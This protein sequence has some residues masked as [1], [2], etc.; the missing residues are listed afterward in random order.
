[1]AE[2]RG[3]IEGYYGK[4]LTWDER[5]RLLKQMQR[6]GMTGYLYAPKEDALHRWQWRTPYNADWTSRFAAFAKAANAAH[7]DLVA[8]I[9][10]GLD[11][12]FASLGP[13]ASQSDDV[14]GGYLVLLL[15]KARHLLAAGA[16]G[17]AL[18]M[19]DIDANFATR[20]GAFTSE[21]VAHA[22]LANRL[23][24]AL[25]APLMLVPRIY[26]DSLIQPDDLHSIGYLADVT[27]VLAPSVRL[28]YCGDDIVA[29]RPGRD[30]AGLLNPREVTVW[31]NFYAN[32]YCPRRLF[33]GPWRARG[34]HQSLWLN[35][36]GMIETDLLLLAIMQES[37]DVDSDAA[38][39]A[40]WDRV[41]AAHDVPEAFRVVAG[42]F[43]APYGFEPA[44]TLPDTA[45]ALVALDQLLWRWKSPL[46]REWYP[47]LMGLK[48]DLAIGD[49]TLP[50]IR[51]QKTQLAP[52]SKRLDDARR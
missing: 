25:D 7:I 18:L 3:Y 38:R 40:A 48:H 26:A 23:A 29:Q 10:P 35:P 12:D 2:A 42:F 21:G 46:Q 13:D 16:T 30:A 5:A 17:I 15:A 41:M 28:I 33:V 47:L 43:D 19:D 14:A 32:D 51:L 52:L 27:A 24:A 45:A 1:M 20:C 36:T 50:L 31:D 9:A 4:L 39:H 37:R 8:G 22:T 44:F 49:N 6:L 34:H 11:F